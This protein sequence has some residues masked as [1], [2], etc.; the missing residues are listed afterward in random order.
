MQIFR[1]LAGY[2]LGRADVVR[3]AMSK[4]KHDV[5]E[6]EREIFINGLVNED[7]TVEV[8]GC[9]RRG[10]DRSCAESVYEEMKSFASYAFNKSHAA[11]YAYISYQTAWLKY[12][13]PRQYMAALLSSVLD[14]QNKLSVYIADCHHNG[15]EV[16]PPHVNFSSHGFTVVGGN[17]RYGLMAIKNLGYN[18]IDAIL[19]AR[20]N[21]EFT[22]LKD[23]CSRLY[24]KGMNSRSLES[25]IKCGALDGLG[26]N[27]RQMLTVAKSVLDDLEYEK[28]R[29]IDGQMSLFETTSEI[30][31]ETTVN[32]P[33]V[34][35]YSLIDLLT[36]EKDM[37]GMYLSGHPISE[38]EWYSKKHRVDRIGDIISS[39]SEKKYK[40]N[41]RVRLLC[42]VSRFRSQLTKSNQMMAFVTVEDRSGSVELI[43]F[44][45][46]LSQFGGLLYEGAV[47]SVT[48]NVSSREDEDSKI[49]VNTVEKVEKSDSSPISYE[50]NIPQ[51]EDKTVSDSI[52]DDLSKV[53]SLYLKVD[54]KDGPLFKKA[55][56]LISIFD[57][58]T[59]VF[60]YLEEEKKVLKAPRNLWVDLNKVMLCELRNQLGEDS[61]K[62]K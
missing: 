4:K 56:N 54:K 55:Y 30:K 48:G 49:L 20:R 16:L 38:Y 18:F 8:E 51:S 40:D 36:M 46:T 28:R 50:R 34:P 25:L 5:M 24:S 37:A 59:P 13:Y 6:Q 44:P 32:Y 58:N 42:I 21:G 7:G 61:V 2:S 53:S 9:I 57:G 35:E 23:F 43:V 19:N 31:E 10:V 52:H 45:K 27:R 17:I 1:K 14:N 22:S 60:F 47:V 15:I 29:N 33:D 41:D 62:L 11:S 3:R 39:E 26:A 12:H